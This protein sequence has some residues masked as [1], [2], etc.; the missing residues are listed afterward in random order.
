[1]IKLILS[2]TD[3]K[4]FAAFKERYS[5]WDIHRLEDGSLIFVPPNKVLVL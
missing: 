1:M 5:G 2:E 3:K 4:M